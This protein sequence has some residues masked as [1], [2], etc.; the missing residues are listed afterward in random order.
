MLELR[1]NCELCDVD[2]PANAQNA[3]ICT[4]ECTYC[5]DCVETLSNVCPNCGGGFSPRPIRPQTAWRPGVSLGHQKPSQKRIHSRY[6]R[7]DLTD[8]IDRIKSTPPDKR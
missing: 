4:Y 3:M 5:A 7:D 8:Y 2:L 6:K 1:P